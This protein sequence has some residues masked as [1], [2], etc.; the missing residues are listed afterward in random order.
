MSVQSKL[1]DWGTKATESATALKEALDG[2]YW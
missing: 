2:A 1:R